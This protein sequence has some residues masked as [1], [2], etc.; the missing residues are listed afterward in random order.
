MQIINHTST[1]SFYI[2]IMHLNMIKKI[3]LCSI[4]SISFS[5]FSSKSYSIPTIRDTEIENLIKDM[6][7]PLLEAADL[8][9]SSVKFYIVNDDQ[10]NA[11]V[12][13]GSNIIY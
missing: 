3:V 7:R 2:I 12:F 9:P 13:G 8:K 11:F 4:I 10:I 1:I 5:L 6:S